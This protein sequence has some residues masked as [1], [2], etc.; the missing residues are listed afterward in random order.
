MPD[1]LFLAHRIPYP[2]DKGDKIRSFHILRHLARRWRVHLGCFVDDPEDWAHVERL[3]GMCAQVCAIPLDPRRRRLL[4][5]RGLVDG[6][7]LTFTYYASRTL[8]RWVAEVR[9]AHAPTLELAFS[10]G[11]APYVARC[12]DRGRALRVVDLV[13]LDSEKW[14]AY[15]AAGRGFVAGLHA[16]EA[17]RLAAAE[18]A[19]THAVDATL[20]VSAAE[21]ADLRRRPGVRSSG[22]HVL[23][24]G[25]DL[26]F[27]DPAVAC[28]FLHPMPEAAGAPALVFTG[29]MD[30]RANVD[31]VLWFADAVWPAL[32]EAEPE[33]RWWIVGSRPD[34]R[35]VALASRPGITV[36]GRVPDVRPWLAH[37]TLA[38]AP[39]R[40]ARG[41]QNKLLEALAMG[42][43]VVATRNAAIGLDPTTRAVLT[44]ADEPAAM[45]AAILRLLADSESRARRARAGR[46][47]MA[48]A[49]GWPAQLAALDRLLMGLPGGDGASLEAAA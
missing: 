1:A 25:V 24:N 2:P 17:K 12:G 21:A 16:R 39:L 40:I 7:P 31:A 5:L 19:L 42:C 34:R 4:A 27:F 11:V 35:V 6:Q 38:V 47:R 26:D 41:V 14:A 30:Y 32:R 18:V 49:Y 28:A 23:G 9:A 44:L 48:E 15:A 3:K 43:P 33:L 13:D 20:L 29:A 10:S 46:A 22:V 8:A 45:A 37:A 36:T